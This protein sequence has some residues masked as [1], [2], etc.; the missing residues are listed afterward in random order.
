TAGSVSAPA[1]SPDGKW[2]AFK[3]QYKSSSSIFG[4]PSVGGDE[5]KLVDLMLVGAS[6]V[7]DWSPD[8]RQLIFSDYVSNSDRRLAIYLFD[9]PAG[10][11]RRLTSPAS[12]EFADWDPKFSPDGRVVAFKRVGGYWDDAIYTVPVAGGE[13]RRVTWQKGGIWGHA[14][15]RDGKSLIL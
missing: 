9:V 14:W 2:I 5:K 6:Y 12:L 11:K 3:R 15:S 1:W 13:S 4:I 8:G 7:I 10:E